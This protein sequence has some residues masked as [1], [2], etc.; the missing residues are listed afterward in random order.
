VALTATSISKVSRICTAAFLISL[1]STAT[2]AFETQPSAAATH[3]CHP[4]TNGGRCYEPGEYCRHTD[5]G[6]RGIA[7]D[8]KRIIC[9][10]NDGLRWEPY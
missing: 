7:G 1:L 5:R 8:G 4:L 2:V 10:N 3:R 9:R 6:V